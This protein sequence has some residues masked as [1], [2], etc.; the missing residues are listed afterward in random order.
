M[1]CLAIAFAIPIGILAWLF[2]RQFNA[3]RA[4]RELATRNGLK[5]QSGRRWEI[6]RLGSVAGTY[7]GRPLSLRA[8]YDSEDQ[9]TGLQ[10]VLRVDNRA[11]GH[12]KMVY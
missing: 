2:I 1:E 9:L 7:R 4:W 8:V 3:I 12:L 6:P 10:A 11:N 5:Y